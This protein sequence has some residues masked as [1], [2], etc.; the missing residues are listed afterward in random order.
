[1]A[2]RALL[3]RELW[4]TLEAV[5][6]VVYFAPGAKAAYGALGLRGYWMGYFASRSAALGTPG[7]RLVTALFYGFAPRMV[8]RA[9]PDAWA[10][11]DRARVLDTRSELARS[12]LAEHAGDGLADA[13][14]LLASVLAALDVAGRPLAAAH[15]DVP[16]PADPL[17]RIWH[18]ATVLREYRGDGHVAELVAA[19]VDGAE[20]HL[21]HG[22]SLVSQQREFRGWTEEE[23]ADAGERLRARGLLDA[24]GEKTP[25]GHELR[26]EIERGTDRSA[27]AAL[28]T[29]GASELRELCDGLRP[30]AESLANSGAVPYPNAMGVARPA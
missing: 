5:H 17:S 19:Q 14:D 10:F 4:R 2:E 16:V 13:A 1:M 26:T 24:A 29:L 6:A 20:C 7:P 11:A 18:A 27:A 22:G 9:L 25:R 15:L 28:R 23:W 8:E 12:A 21:L 3:E 30:V